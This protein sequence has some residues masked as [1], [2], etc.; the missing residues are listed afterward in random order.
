[1][2]WPVFFVVIQG[3]QEFIFGLF[4]FPLL[5]QIISFGR[6]RFG[7]RLHGPAELLQQYQT[8][9]QYLE[10]VHAEAGS[11]FRHGEVGGAERTAHEVLHAHGEQIGLRTAKYRLQVE[12]AE[13]ALAEL[14]AAIERNDF[15]AEREERF[16]RYLK[17][18]KTF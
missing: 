14:N 5:I 4:P 13:E 18:V 8:P 3:L 15:A 6:V 7:L 2:R 12:T 17:E 9:G 11:G 10:L 16:S 1:M